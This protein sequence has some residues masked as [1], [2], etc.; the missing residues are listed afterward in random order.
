M[1]VIEELLR[2]RAEHYEQ[3]TELKGVKELDGWRNEFPAELKERHE[4]GELYINKDELKKLMSWKLN[5][6][7]YRASLPKLIEQND[8]KLVIQCSRGAFAL[9]LKES[10]DDYIK[11][12]KSAMSTICKLRGVG[13][14]TGS[15]VLSL[16]SEI[17]HR[18]PPF[19]SDEA[20]IYVLSDLGAYKGKL[21]YSTAEY[22]K[23]LAWFEDLDPT[24]EYNRT[25]LEQAAWC[26]QLKS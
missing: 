20:G 24:R 19:F 14:A 11:T 18:A 6:G 13:P 2:S 10:D 17:T 3:L 23:Y 16:L 8:P 7:K 21:Q 15:L 4:K 12:M 1:R 26:E 5:K 22:F 9:V 25:L